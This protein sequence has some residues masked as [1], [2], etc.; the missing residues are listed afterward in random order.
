MEQTSWWRWDPIFKQTP[1]Q[2]GLR[3]D[4]YL[5]QA[6]AGYLEA[7][8]SPKD[9]SVAK[10]H[11]SA[12]LS[13]L[14]DPEGSNEAHLAQFAH[15]GM[16]SGFIDKE[17]WRLTFEPLLHQSI[18]SEFE[19]RDQRQREFAAFHEIV[20]PFAEGILLKSQLLSKAQLNGPQ[21]EAVRS[22]I[23]VDIRKVGDL[24]V[25]HLRPVDVSVAATEIF[26][27]TGQ[28]QLEQLEHLTWQK[29]PTLDPGREHL[30]LEHVCPVAEL[31]D[32]ALR[33]KS[34]LEVVQLLWTHMRLAWVTRAEDEKLTELGYK[35]VRPYPLVAYSYAGINV[36]HLNRV[37][38]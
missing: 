7:E 12:V 9:A 21:L 4:S 11:L 15:G 25:P 10:S 29:Q 20:L 18:E 30:I 35:K 24:V 6:L 19:K 17:A 23:S 38:T 34:G 2:W 5:W 27:P 3:G 22:S 37:R 13:N 33:A 32:R 14:L 28:F 1:E 26:T 31:R 16:S 8:S 36:F